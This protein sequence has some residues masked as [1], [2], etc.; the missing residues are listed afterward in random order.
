MCASV[1]T[2]VKCLS[3]VESVS[4]SSQSHGQLFCDAQLMVKT[5]SMTR[6]EN[7]ATADAADAAAAAAA[8]R[9]RER[10]VTSR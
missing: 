9:R 1:V 3:K 5:R 6:A 2:G 4:P 8:A 10:Q 7:A